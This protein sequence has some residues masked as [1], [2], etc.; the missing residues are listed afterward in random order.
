[1]A[2]PRKDASPDIFT[3]AEVAAAAGISPR[4]FG[5]LIENGL[6]PRAVVEAAGKGGARYWDTRG[7]SEAAVI[8]AIH[9]SGAELLMAGRIGREIVGH[10]VATRGRLPSNLTFFHRRISGFQLPSTQVEVDVTPPDLADFWVHQTLRGHPEVYQPGM[11]LDGDLTIEIADRRAVFIDV[12]ASEGRRLPRL[13][14]WG[15]DA[16]AE[17]ELLL[18]VEGW[19]R[20]ADATIRLVDELIDWRGAMDDPAARDAAKRVEERWLSARRNAIG[21]LLVNASLAI[22]SA[23][24]AVYDH[25]LMTAKP[26]SNERQG[27]ADPP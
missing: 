27:G 2:R 10:F 4:N 21:R 1:M 8:G 20:G 5:V 12:W 25:R 16:S 19:E 11:A 14:P 7:L 26:F 13:S 6:A 3:S 17:P 24:D 18:V 23:L 9:R 15:A 22:R